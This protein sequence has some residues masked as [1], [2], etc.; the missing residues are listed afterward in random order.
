MSWN[1]ERSVKTIL[2][3]CFDRLSY[4]GV[5]MA[6]IV[7]KM[8]RHLVQA[9]EL[10]EPMGRTA[11][12]KIKIGADHEDEKLI[13]ALPS[14]PESSSKESNNSSLPRG[15]PCRRKK[16]REILLLSATARTQRRSSSLLYLTTI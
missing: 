2:I 4:L 6:A 3:R 5:F 9:D 1:Y 10:A 15:N 7:E 13:D 12:S 16:R 11:Q 8:Q 14:D